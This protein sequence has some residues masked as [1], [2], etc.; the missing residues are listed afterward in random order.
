LR[1]EV[2]RLQRRT[3]PLLLGRA[4][5]RSGDA[6]L[7]P[8]KPGPPYIPEGAADRQGNCSKRAVQCV[9]ARARVLPFP[10]TDRFSL[11]DDDCTDCLAVLCFRAE[12]MHAESSWTRWVQKARM[13]NRHSWRAF[14]HRISTPQTQKVVRACAA[15][16]RKG[17]AWVA[18]GVAAGGASSRR[19]KQATR[20]IAATGTGSS[21][22]VAVR[23]TKLTPTSPQQVSLAAAQRHTL[24]IGSLVV[25]SGVGLGYQVGG[26][27]AWTVFAGIGSYA[28]WVLAYAEL[29]VQA[30]RRR[31]ASTSRRSSSAAMSNPEPEEGPA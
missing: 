11:R 29:T 6:H 8:G 30:N 24:D 3:T 25:L 16:E 22:K 12:P 5:N 23:G 7:R 4:P 20:R 21:V 10:P 15:I 14:A 26:W 1:E 28:I 2:N 13:S 18:L 17:T 27:P 31:G 9:W 19:L